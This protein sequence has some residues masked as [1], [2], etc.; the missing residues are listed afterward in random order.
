MKQGLENL[1]RSWVNDPEEQEAML[2]NEL[3]FEN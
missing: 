1:E 2:H 3:V